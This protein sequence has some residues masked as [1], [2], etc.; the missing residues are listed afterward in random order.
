MVTM[1]IIIN[2]NQVIYTLGPAHAWGER[3]GSWD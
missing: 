1:A 3:V 2:S